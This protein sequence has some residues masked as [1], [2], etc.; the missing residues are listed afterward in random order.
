MVSPARRAR[1]TWVLVAAELDPAPQVV[2]DD[3]IYDN[4]VEDLLGVIADTDPGVTTLGLVGHSPA[5]ADL[6]VALDGGRGN[7]PAMA[8][9]ARK[10]PTSGIAVFDID[11]EWA[12][13]GR[14]AGRLLHFTAPRHLKA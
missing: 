7:S 9:L 3:R 10:Y 4:T 8:E 6:S 13:V 14:G 5:I 1:Q 11:S 2:V 12:H